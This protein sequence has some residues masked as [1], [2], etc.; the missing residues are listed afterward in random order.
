MSFAVFAAGGVSEVRKQVE[1]SM[2]V[3]GTIV[4]DT[5]GKL[6][7]LTL[8]HEDALPT[9]A[10]RLIRDQAAQWRF[11]PVM[12]NGKAVVAKTDMSLRV[13]AKALPN[14]EYAIRIGGASFGTDS[15]NPNEIIRGEKLTPPD[16]PKA[17]AS[18]GATGTAYVV[19]KVGRNGRVEDVI[20]EQVNLNVVARER[21][22]DAIRR[23][24]A[25]NAKAG[26]KKW[27]FRPP[28][29]GDEADDEFW[30]VRVPVKYNLV[31]VRPKKTYGAWEAYV[32]GP[33]QP[34]TWKSEAESPA[35]SPDAAPEGS[36]R[37]AGS[38]LRLLT[39]PGG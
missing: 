31:R 2:L 38:G 17:A 35:F 12:I 5:G 37:L 13:I 3:T 18:I 14:D 19:V 25:N 29:E 15:P 22:M 33:R 9:G 1:A 23:L 26:A 4:V 28:T 16:F 6:K 20:V 39:A 27:T 34:I 10:V 21:D 8:D 30:T 32:S 7:A 24:F 11:E 36:V